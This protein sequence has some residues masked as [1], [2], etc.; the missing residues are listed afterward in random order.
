VW[1]HDVAYLRELLLS[2]LD[3]ARHQSAAIRDQSVGGCDH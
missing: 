2:A 1:D 3:R